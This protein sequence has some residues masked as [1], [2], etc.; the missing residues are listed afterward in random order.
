MNTNN[1]STTQDTVYKSDPKGYM[2]NWYQANREKTRADREANREANK[3]KLKAYQLANRERIRATNTAYR[4]ANK[5]KLNA[6]NTVYR[7][8][9]KEKL[10]AYRQSDKAKAY[11]LANKLCESLRGRCS[12]LLKQAGIGKDIL[13]GSKMTQHVINLLGCSI[14][15]A[16]KH[17]E[18]Q[19]VE[20]MSW[21]N[22][23]YW[24]WHIDHIR[25]CSSFD[26]LD[27]AQQ[28]ECFHYTNLQ[29]LWAE[30]NLAKGAKWDD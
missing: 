27:P 1:N 21:S 13:T 12:A 6:T 2:K 14:K 28:A 24:T 4:L 29:P 30:D 5:D 20:G 18:L 8:A 25:P 3:E 23:N 9:N 7:L 17:I 15:E 16:A 11:R 26:L 19:F 10:K 22:Y